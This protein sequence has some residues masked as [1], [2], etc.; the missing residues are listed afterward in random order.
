MTQSF[1]EDPG[2][3]GT[4]TAR[5]DLIPAGIETETETVPD[6]LVADYSSLTTPYCWVIT[7]DLAA[8]YDGDQPSA[9]G[10]YGPARAEAEDI[11]EA[12]SSGK[13]FRLADEAGAALAIGRIY[14]PSGENDRAPLDDLSHLD[15]ATWEPAV[16]E[17][18]L[19]GEWEAG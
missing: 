12:L 7:E 18:R 14:D 17:Y 13:W 11:R 5:G 8:G 2:P 16:I 1:E 10:R 15:E 3:I 9:V 19:S 6:E 4:G